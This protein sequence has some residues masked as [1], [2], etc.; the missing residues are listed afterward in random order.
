MYNLNSLL[1]EIIG[2]PTE[3]IISDDIFCGE[4]N[5]S[6]TLLGN[7]M[8]KSLSCFTFTIVRKGYCI[9]EHNGL[10]IKLNPGDMYVFTP[11]QSLKIKE[12][13]EEY[14][15]IC[16]LVTDKTAFENSYAHNII[17][18]EYYSKIKYEKPVLHLP[19]QLTDKLSLILREI[20][21]YQLSD[22]SL[23][24]EACKALFSL[25]L[26]EIF[27]YL[28]QETNLSSFSKK[29]EVSVLKFLKLVT[30]HYKEHHNLE[31]YS[32]TLCISNA[33]LSRIVKDVTG[34]T[35]V[36]HINNMLIMEAAWL[37]NATDM[38]IKEIAYTLHFS[39][40]ASFSKFFKRLKG[41]SPK[42]YRK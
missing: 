27:H 38:S 36:E 16:L 35:V 22:N 12:I 28:E 23:K 34:I 14:K 37:L 32:E 40:Q 13:S 5:A 19:A 41:C 39:D 26:I 1:R 7:N 42:S 31:F 4:T 21:N 18:A 17:R 10:I 3:R 20:I 8:Q 15:G 2:I 33:Y 30:N 25:F 29:K 6:V 11:G 24:T 9:I